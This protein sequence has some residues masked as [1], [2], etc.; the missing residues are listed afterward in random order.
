MYNVFV[1][2]IDARHL[3]AKD[4]SQEGGTSDPAVLVSCMGLEPRRTRE[5]SSE[6]NPIWDEWVVL[7]S[8]PMRTES[9]RDFGQLLLQVVDRDKGV[10]FDNGPLSKD[11]EIG[12]FELDMQHVWERPGHCMENAWV[13]LTNGSLDEDS[14]N[15]HADSVVQGSLQGV[16]RISVFIRL[17]GDANPNDNECTEEPGAHTVDPGAGLGGLLEPAFTLQDY[18]L[19]ISCSEFEVGE[20]FD[21][22]FDVRNHTRIVRVGT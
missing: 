17:V 11:E 19:T 3:A 10:V 18:V 8:V 6:L 13:P 20:G 4:G 22:P 15:E 12:A 9:P 1:H 2:C 16:L 7:N 5:V 14:D 21:G